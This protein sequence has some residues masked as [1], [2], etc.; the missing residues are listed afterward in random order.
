MLQIPTASNRMRN[1][2]EHCRSS[3]DTNR[4][5]QNLK[6]QITTNYI[7]TVWKKN[8]NTFS[9]PYIHVNKRTPPIR[10][11]VAGAEAILQLQRTDTLFQSDSSLRSLRAHVR[12][13][14]VSRSR[15]AE[16]SKNKSLKERLKQYYYTGIYMQICSRDVVRKKKN[17][18]VPWYHFSW[19][20]PR[21][22]PTEP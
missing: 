19:I 17:P 4:C 12:C 13:L 18:I 5:T 1:E 6:I 9:N 10:L 22:A 7:F 8:E 21:E 3:D 15:R 14:L 11:A 16:R 20:S 2:C